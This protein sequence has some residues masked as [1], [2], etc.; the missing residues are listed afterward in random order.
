M[1][2]NT[3]QIL[4]QTIWFSFTFGAIGVMANFTLLNFYSVTWFIGIIRLKEIAI[5]KHNFK[6]ELVWDWG[7]T[8]LLTLIS[9]YQFQ[10]WSIPINLFLE[11]K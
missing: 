6:K 5:K 9:I 1:R 8:L 3:S 11:F 10:K 2:W 7:I 4:I